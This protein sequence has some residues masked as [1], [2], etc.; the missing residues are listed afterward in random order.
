MSPF[1]IIVELRMTG[2]V[3]GDNW[4]C[5]TCSQIVTTNKPTLNFLQAG[6]PSCRKTI[7]VKALKGKVSLSTDLLILSSP[8]GIPTLSL[9]SV[10]MFQSL[11]FQQNS[12]KLQQC[13]FKP[14]TIGLQNR[15]FGNWLRRPNLQWSSK[16]KLVKQNMKVV[17]PVIVVA[18]FIL[19]FIHSS[20]GGMASEG[21]WEAWQPSPKVTR[22]Y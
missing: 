2:V 18:I 14:G 12:D 20:I 1:W 4:S 22:S 5:K 10:K 17:V 9:N 13:A 19:V 8:A 11:Q 15:I 7:S 21:W 6:C 16:N 3:S